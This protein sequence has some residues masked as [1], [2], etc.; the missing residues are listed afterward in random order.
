MSPML[1]SWMRSRN[2]RP[3]FMYRLAIDTTRRRLAWIISC[4]APRAPSSAARMSRTARWSAPSGMPTSRS[5]SAS[6]RRAA[7]ALQRDPLAGRAIGALG[8]VREAAR[9][10]EQLGRRAAGALLDGLEARPPR[11]RPLE[12][13]IEPARHVLDL[14]AREPE[15]AERA[16]ETRLEAGA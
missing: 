14:P 5:T 4:L 7:R 9:Q 1:P 15:P 2:W 13:G 16:Q 12:A 6:S 10:A 3:R 11:R 8:A